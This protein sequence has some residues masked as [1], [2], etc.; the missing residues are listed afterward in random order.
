VVLRKLEAIQQLQGSAATDE[1]RPSKIGPISLGAKRTGKRS[2]GNREA[3]HMWSRSAAYFAATVI[4]SAS[5]STDIV[6]EFLS[7]TM[8]GKWR[9]FKK[10]HNRFPLGNFQRG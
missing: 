2:A 5:T 9:A 7:C 10:G 4:H 8:D 3:L 1:I 6:T